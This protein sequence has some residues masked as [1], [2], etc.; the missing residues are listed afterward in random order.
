MGEQGRPKGEGR[1]SLRRTP[2]VMKGL[3]SVVQIRAAA[4]SERAIK[5]ESI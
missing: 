2:F 5:R 1:V 3:V 4:E